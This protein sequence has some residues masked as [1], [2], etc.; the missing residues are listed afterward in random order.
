MI[1]KIGL[2]FCL[3]FGLTQKLNPK[4]LLE[5]SNILNFEG[6]EWIEGKK[7]YFNIS[8]QLIIVII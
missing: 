4:L 1:S 8:I 2:S 5:I 7:V 3:S 6:I